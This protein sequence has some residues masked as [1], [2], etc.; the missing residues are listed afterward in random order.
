[1]L[2]N[3]NPNPHTQTTDNFVATLTEIK[4]RNLASRLV[5]YE[6][7][8]DPR[9]APSPAQGIAVRRIVLTDRRIAVDQQCKDHNDA[10]TSLGQ[11][12]DWLRALQESRI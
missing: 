12:S 5:K 3:E 1:M 6:H 7:N 9:E 8:P 11:G 10:V 2:S 4:S